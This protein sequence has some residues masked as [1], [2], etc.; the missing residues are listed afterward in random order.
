M[1][2]FIF[3][4]QNWNPGA[5][6]ADTS[7][8][9]SGSIFMALR[10]GSTTQ[11]VKVKEF[12]L[13]GFA[14]AST[15]SLLNFARSSTIAT[16]PTALAAPASDGPMDA[17]TAVL[18]APTVSFTVASTG[19]Q[20]SAVTTSGK[21]N[22][23]MNLFGGIL[24]YNAGPGQEFTVIGNTGILSEAFLSAFTGSASGAMSADIIYEVA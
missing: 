15:I 22:L 18:A 3:T 16:T 5:G 7:A 24:K 19:P 11:Y 23:G 17:T 21:I 6:T 10:G 12:M 8:L 2:H 20:R 14:A 9:A 13:S 1:S 4:N